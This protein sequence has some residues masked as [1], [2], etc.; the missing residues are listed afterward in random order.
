MHIGIMSSIA[1]LLHNMIEGMAVY[2][3]TIESV[4]VGL[5]VALGV[6]LHN[7]PMGMIIAATL[8]HEPKKVRWSILSV[9]VVST[10]IGGL[11]MFALSSLMTDFVI[12][13]L[14]SLTLGMLL[15]IIV[16]ELIPHLLHG[17]NKVRSLLFALAGVCLILISSLFE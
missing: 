4:R 15:Y 10:F 5:L 14:I 6:G 9:A 1:V 13:L 7:I 17:Q 12:G 3:L 16:F 11:L 8:E 2:S